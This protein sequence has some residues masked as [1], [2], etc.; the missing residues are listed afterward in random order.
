MA[1]EDLDEYLDF[2]EK[3]KSTKEKIE[4]ILEILAEPDI[5]IWET[6]HIKREAEYALSRNAKKLEELLL[7]SNCMHT[8][9]FEGI[10]QGSDSHKSYYAN[11]C[12][13]CGK[14]LR[15]YSI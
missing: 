5:D 14:T 12:S 1:Q 13:G 4:R 10:F 8:E 11:I 9:V 2:K 6:H 15:E 3:S 7:R